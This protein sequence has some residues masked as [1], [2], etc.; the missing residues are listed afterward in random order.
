MPAKQ[1]FVEL[2]GLR[3]TVDQVVYSPTPDGPDGSPHRF[4]Y[5]ISIRNDSEETVSIKGRKWVVTNDQGETVVVEG[6]G[7]VGQF[8]TIRPGEHFTYN[9]FHLLRTLRGRAE[10]SYFGLDSQGR[11]VITRI[12][13]FDL[14]VPRDV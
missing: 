11:P 5:F 1:K 8:P 14:I 10:G 7:V 2:D 12:P 13:A 4:I 3:V 6:D 9:S